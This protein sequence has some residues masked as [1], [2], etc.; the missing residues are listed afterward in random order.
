V[1]HITLP[2]SLASDRNIVSRENGGDRSKAN[3][4]SYS[5]STGS[6]IF[7]AKDPP[8]YLNTRKCAGAKHF[9]HNCPHTSKEKVGALLAEYKNRLH[10]GRTAFTMFCDQHV[11]PPLGSERPSAPAGVVA[12][13]SHSARPT[14]RALLD[15]RVRCSLFLAPRSRRLSFSEPRLVA[16]DILCSARFLGSSRSFLRFR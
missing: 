4:S 1:Q 7:D 8:A 5:C 6:C 10:L 11:V 12:V 13:Q 9:L 14:E 2:C 16:F 15:C 3:K